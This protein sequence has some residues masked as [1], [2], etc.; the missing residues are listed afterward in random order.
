MAVLVDLPEGVF[1][2]DT[3]FGRFGLRA[4]L[5]LSQ[6]LTPVQQDWDQFRLR[7]EQHE[8]IVEAWSNNVWEAQF[9][10]DEYPAEWVDFMPANYFNSHSP[11]TIFVQKMLI[12]QHQPDARIILLGDNLKTIRADGIKEQTLTEPLAERLARFGLTWPVV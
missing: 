10:F 1:F 4:P 8:W 3:G 7:K 6:E 9:S 12:I 11:E 2:C 5:H